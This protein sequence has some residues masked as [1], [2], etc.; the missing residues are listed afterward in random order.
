[1]ANVLKQQPVATLTRRGFQW[2]AKETP[3]DQ[4]RNPNE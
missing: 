4:T 3:N 2:A 1:V